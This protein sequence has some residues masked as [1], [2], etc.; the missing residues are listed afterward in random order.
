MEY[1]N[2][3]LPGAPL[4]IFE[5]KDPSAMAMAYFIWHPALKKYDNLIRTV[6]PKFL[7]RAKNLV[8][9]ITESGY[10]VANKKFIWGSN[11]MTLEEGIILCQA[12]E[13]NNNPDFLAA[14]RDQLHYIFG[15][16]YFGKSFVSGVGS[17]S[18]KNVNHLFGTAANLKIPGLLVGGPNEYEQSNIAPKNVGLRSWIDDA[19]SYATNEYAIDY[20]SSL[21]GLISALK[22]NC[23]VINR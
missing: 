21:I 16:N 18:V 19:R 6:R 22:N 8:K 12:Y 23:Y 10:R 14:A 17:N 1:I 7:L 5:W 9:N 15:R 2:K 11:K 13:I 20:N 4:S 3:Y